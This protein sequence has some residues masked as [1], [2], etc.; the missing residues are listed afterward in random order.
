[1]LAFAAGFLLPS[2]ALI[3]GQITRAYSPGNKNVLTDLKN[4]MILVTIMAFV[5]WLLSYAFYVIL[6]IVA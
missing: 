6:R 2:L 1:M 4:V 3:F 5:I